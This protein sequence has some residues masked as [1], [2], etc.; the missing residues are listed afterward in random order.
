MLSLLLFN[1]FLADVEEVMGKSK[2]GR[3]KIGG[4]ED[5]YW[6]MRTIWC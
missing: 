4:K 5:F 6:D 3:D 1:I 2:V